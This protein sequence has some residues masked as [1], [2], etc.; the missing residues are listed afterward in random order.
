[1]SRNEQ[2]VERGPHDDETALENI[3][4]LLRHYSD[5]RKEALE[6]GD[7]IA[8]AYYSGQMSGLIHAQEAVE[9]D[10]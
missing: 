2:D 10:E 4:K 5:K 6:E 7:E 1:M 8:S 3:K 9:N